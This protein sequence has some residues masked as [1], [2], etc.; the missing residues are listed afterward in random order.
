[1]G[2]DTIG[3]YRLQKIIGSG[4]SSVVYEGMSQTGAGPFAVKV[5]SEE[6]SNDNVNSRRVVREIKILRLIEHPNVV[7]IHDYG[8]DETRFY[9]VMEL[10][11]G[12]LLSKVIRQYTWIPED[13]AVIILGQLCEAMAAVHSAGI[14]HRDLKPSNIM[15][16]PK[17]VVKLID[18]GV[19]KLEGDSFLKTQTGLVLG[20]I[21]YMS[22]EQVR[23]AQLDARSDIFAMGLIFFEMLF[24]RGL[25][26]ASTFMDY[27]EK[28]TSGSLEP[29]RKLLS[30]I[31]PKVSEILQ[32]MLR[33]SADDRYQ[34]VKDLF[35]DLKQAAGTMNKPSTTMDFLSRMPFFSEFTPME[36]RELSKITRIKTCH[37]AETVVEEGT[38]GRELFFIKNGQF[39]VLKSVGGAGT[40][41]LATLEKDMVFGEM[42]FFEENLPLRSATIKS[43]GCGEVAVLTH[44]SLAGL[45][46]RCPDMMMKTYRAVIS[47]MTNRLKLTNERLAHTR[48]TLKN[49]TGLIN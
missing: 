13:K 3:K 10:L 7:R 41:L 26:Q 20:T 8:L 16:T 6:L 39:D 22:P 18:F 37:E 21:S 9:I 36:L 47:M 17:G 34:N 45:H 23:G 19:S 32:K 48:I 35:R 46:G 33:P 29:D 40:E 38:W 11:E 4:A 1:M 14:V 49:F 44:E 42:S 30:V 31:D 27:Y 28:M 5:L 12:A 24:G 43:V 15:V 25:V 2:S